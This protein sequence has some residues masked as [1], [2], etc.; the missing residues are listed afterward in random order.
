MPPFDTEQKVKQYIKDFEVTAEKYLAPYRQWLHS[1]F[2][3]TVWS[4]QLCA[5]LIFWNMVTMLEATYFLTRWLLPFDQLDW[6]N[7]KQTLAATG[8]PQA[9][10]QHRLVDD[11]EMIITGNMEIPPVIFDQDFSIVTERGEGSTAD[12]SRPV[13]ALE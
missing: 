12:G 13:S 5:A 11:P 3:P 6:N 1:V 7:I 8:L 9:C 10:D 4:I 2:P